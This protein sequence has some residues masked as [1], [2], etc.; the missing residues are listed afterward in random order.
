MAAVNYPELEEHKA[1][2]AKL[3][4]E[5]LNFQSRITESFPDGARELYH[6]LRNWLL[7]HIQDSDKKYGPYLNESEGTL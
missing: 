3:K 4:E 6:F 7:N 5:A 1:E 2:H